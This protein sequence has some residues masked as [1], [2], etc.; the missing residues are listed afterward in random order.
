MQRL[1]DTELSKP[2]SEVLEII[3]KLGKGSY[4]S[5]YKARYKANGGIVAVKK[6]R[7]IHRDIKAGNILLLN[8]GAAKLADFG[9][10]GQLSD[11]LAKRNTVIGTP[12]WMAP[13]VIQEIG[14]NCSA[15]IWSLGITAIE[16]ADGKPPLA[17]IHP[18]RALFMIPSQPAPALRKPSNWSLEF[19]AFIAACLAK[20]PEA[21]PTA[22]ALL[23]TE[24]IRNAKPCSI[25]LQLIN[26]A[27]EARERRLLQQQQQ[28]QTSTPDTPISDVK[29]RHSVM[30]K[31][32]E[33]QVKSKQNQ[34]SQ[35]DV[36]DNL[37]TMVRSNS[38]SSRTA[39][40]NINCNNNNES[41]LDIDGAATLVS[42]CSNEDRTNHHNDGDDDDDDDDDDNGSFIRHHDDET[43]VNNAY[44][45]SGNL[46]TMVVNDGGESEEDSGSVVVHDTTGGSSDGLDDAE[47]DQREAFELLDAALP[48]AVPTEGTLT[49]R[50]DKAVKMVNNIGCEQQ[51]NDINNNMNIGGGIGHAPPFI[52]RPFAPFS[53]AIQQSGL[54]TNGL[55]NEPGSLSR[56]SYA[57]LEQL[58]ISLTNDL[59][60]EL[61][62]LAVRY[63]HKRQPLLDAIA[64]KTAQASIKTTNTINNDITSKSNP[65]TQC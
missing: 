25:L 41:G 44:I 40:N 21:R 29:R 51:S 55:T 18:M 56:L 32:D 26:E 5:V 9:V 24:F 52:Q 28:Q 59:E 13:E 47:R 10:A 7:K 22:A 61:R 23:Q 34:L 16:M 38:T 54:Y 62:N 35:D 60:T 12:Y 4:G 14:Y 58:L 31:I 3:C 39:N 63:R 65:I 33:N 20:S 15:D 45:S 11:T 57:E 36:D 17:D 2:P 37:H 8:S 46:D 27:N 64:E 53:R 30:N 6:M 42:L 50:I 49:R 43:N 48:P 19:R 1:D